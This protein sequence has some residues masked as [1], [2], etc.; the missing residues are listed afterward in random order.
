MLWCSV[1]GQLCLNVDFKWLC[2]VTTKDLCHSFIYL[3]WDIMC[4]VTNQWYIGG[5]SQ[6]YYLLAS[7]VVVRKYI[8][9]RIIV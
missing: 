9:Y 3:D 2:D 6:S 1:D 4:G 8:V 7:F 5:P